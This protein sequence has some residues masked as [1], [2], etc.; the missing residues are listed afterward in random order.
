VLLVSFIGSGDN[1]GTSGRARL[2]FFMV[3]FPVYFYILN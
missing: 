1:R 2:C 3:V